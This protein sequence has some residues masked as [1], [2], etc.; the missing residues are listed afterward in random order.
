[1]NEHQ[2]KKGKIIILSTPVID[3]KHTEAVKYTNEF[4]DN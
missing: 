1:M 3:K 4:I 2:R